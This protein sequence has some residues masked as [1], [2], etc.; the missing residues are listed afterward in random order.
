MNNCYYYYQANKEI[1]EKATAMLAT[2]PLLPQH[3]PCGEVIEVDEKLA[4]AVPQRIIFTETSQHKE[5]QVTIVTTNTIVCLTIVQHRYIVVR[6]PDGILRQ[7]TW[8]ERDRMCQIFFP[9]LGRKMWLPK[10]LTSEVLPS[11]LDRMMHVSVLDL[12]SVQCDPQSYD[13]HRVSII[14]SQLESWYIH[15]FIQCLI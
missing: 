13:Y 9:A 2:P 7:T 5:N 6:E 1:T 3:L 14:A 11:A 12:V 15:C 8:E 10:I 4:D